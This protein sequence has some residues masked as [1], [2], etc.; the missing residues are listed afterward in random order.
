MKSKAQLAI[1]LSVILL[2]ILAGFLWQAGILPGTAPRPKITIGST[3][4]RIS[5]PFFIAEKEGFFKEQGMDVDLVPHGSSPESIRDLKAGRI[6]LAC[7]GAFNLV[8]D[9]MT[10]KS[11]LRCLAVLCNGQIMDLIARRDRGITRPEDMRGKTIGLPRRTAAA[12][13]L[14]RFLTLHQ[15]LLQEVTLVDFKPID[16]AEA[17]TSGKVDAVVVWEPFTFEI[18][19]KMGPA[20]VTWPAQKGQ[21]IYWLLVG[22]E[23][24]LKNHP[25]ALEKLM[26]GLEQAAKFTRE[27]PEAARAIICRHSKF[28]LTAW[29]RYPL[30]YDICLDQGLLLAMEDE[31]AWMIQNHL[32]DQTKI[33]NFL[34]YLV[35][36]PLRMVNPKAVRLALPG[37][38]IPN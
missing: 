33:P 20:A 31:A 30:R 11:T 18:L 27:R 19:N 12:Y 26:R 10:R 14:G 7:C 38:I 1:V 17:L 35:P 3:V 28:P 29:D 23:T 34:D 25:V 2:L 37:K 15:I 32:T 5:G 36:E 16:L 21:D 4:S 9:V 8:R 13:F 22:R 6:D 24:Y